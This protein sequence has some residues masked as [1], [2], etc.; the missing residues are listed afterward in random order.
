MRAATLLRLA[1]ALVMAA[2][3]LAQAH[4]Q[5]NPMTIVALGASNTAGWGVLPEEA[6][7]VRLQE[8]LAAKGIEAK[9]HNAGIPGDTTGGMLARLDSAVPAGTR[10][11]IL[12]PGTNDASM[13]LS[14]ERE[15]NIEK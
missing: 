3:T 5:A 7:P 12:Q 2:F 9:V 10:L 6:Y 8:M 11:V 1:A 14:G 15:G 13:G 4:T